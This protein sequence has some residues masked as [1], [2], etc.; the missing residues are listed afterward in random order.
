[1]AI[2]LV[3]RASAFPQAAPWHI[4][5][6]AH[7][8]GSTLVL[9]V[10]YSSNGPQIAGVTNTAVDTW[11]RSVASPFQGFAHAHECWYV[12]VTK[13]NPADVVTLTFTGVNSGTDVT[14]VCYEF[15]GGG[16]TL[17]YTGV[18]GSGFS[19]A[20]PLNFIHTGTM[21]ISGSSVVIAAYRNSNDNIPT[22]PSGTQF[23]TGGEG[24]KYDSYQFTSVSGTAHAS[25]T[26]GDPYAQW[27]ILA[28]V[29]A[30][31]AQPPVISSITGC[32][33]DL[34]HPA[35]SGGTGCGGDLP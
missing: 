3:S 2:S 17:T 23:N 32:P 34:P 14:M 35:S 24:T 12:P 4:P 16:A 33:Q 30:L 18:D 20:D 29:F 8:A 22:S 5:A 21:V 15:G 13:G 1:M 27:S 11:Q 25:I 28:S 7:A 31:G 19:P 26:L 9:G 10:I 6:Q